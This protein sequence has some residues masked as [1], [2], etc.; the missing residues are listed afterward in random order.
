MRELAVGAGSLLLLAA[1]LVGSYKGNRESARIPESGYQVH[2]TFNR[3]G[4]VAPGTPV[5]V[6]GIA[7]GAVESIALLPD[8]RAR[9]TM[10]IES[11]LPLPRDTSAAIHTDG[12]FGGK[13]MSLEPGGDPDLLR[14]GSTIAF[15]QDSVVISELL[16]LIIAEGRA[17]RAAAANGG[18]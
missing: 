5:E 18:T 10:R 11:D 7:I 15:T 9:V 12:L 2:A 6:A 3:V 4:G 8:Y 17:N 13:F 14:D 16:D 1:I